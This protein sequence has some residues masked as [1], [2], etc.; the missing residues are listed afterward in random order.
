[1]NGEKYLNKNRWVVAN[2]ASLT[3]EKRAYDIGL[4]VDLQ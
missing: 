2:L 1:M 3:G 4:E